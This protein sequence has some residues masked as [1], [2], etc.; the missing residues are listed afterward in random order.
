MRALA[1]LSRGREAPEGDKI[2][3]HPWGNMITGLLQFEILLCWIITEWTRPTFLWIS[4]NAFLYGKK[5]VKCESVR[6]QKWPLREQWCFPDRVR[7]ENISL[8]HGLG[9]E[10]PSCLMC[11]ACTMGY[12][13][14]SHIVYCHGKVHKVMNIK[15][16]FLECKN[17]RLH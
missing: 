7:A 8:Q 1:N 11:H 13:C 17:K 2:A 10:S 6:H 9:A 15:D 4:A 5:Q 16:V 14:N 3:K 12:I